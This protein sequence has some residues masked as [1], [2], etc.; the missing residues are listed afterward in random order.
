MIQLCSSCLGNG[1]N[2]LKIQ[3]FYFPSDVTLGQRI[4]T[5]CS[6]TWADKQEFLWYKQGKELQKDEKIDIRTFADIS[7]IIIDPVS[8]EHAGN[9]TC[10]VNAEGLTDSYTTTLNVLVPAIWNVVPKDQEVHIGETL[11]LMCA[12]SGKPT[13]IITWKKASVG[14]PD[15]FN[16]IS[17]KEGSIILSNGTMII[18]S[19]T[20]DDDGYYKC[21][22]TNNVGN[23]IEKNILIRVIVPA[24]FEEK[25][26]VQSV[27]RGDS[28]TLKCD[29]VGD[30]PMTIT[31][32]KDKKVID[33][34]KMTRVERFDR[35]QERG[36]NSELVIRTADRNDGALYTCVSKNEY[37]NDER[38]IKL[39]VVEVPAQPLDV[40]I[41]EVYSK[42]AT[43]K[44]SAPY[45]GNSPITKYI[46]QYWR[47]RGGAHRLLEETVPNSQTSI[48]LQ[49]LR[50]G[51]PYSVTVV[52]ENEIGQGEPSDIFRFITG[53]EEPS[54]PPTDVW[55][56]AKGSSMI[57]VSWK[58]PPRE[59][60]NG[61]LK[62]YFIG[63]KIEDPTLPFSFKTVYNV[64]N[65]THEYVLTNLMKSTKYTVVVKAYNSAGTGPPS[66]ELTAKTLDGDLPL[67]PSLALHS[68][69]DSAI[70]VKWGINPNKNIPVSGYTI[71]YK[72]TGGDWYHIPIIANS[73][74]HFTVT[75]L[76]RGTIYDVYITASNQYGNGEAGD[77]LKIKTSTLGFGG[78]VPFYLDLSIIIPVASSLLAFN[79]III[80]IAIYRRKSRARRNLEKALQGAAKPSTYTG[81]SQ[82]YI[83]I[84]KTRPANHPDMGTGA[85]S[86]ASYATI[87]SSQGQDTTQEIKTFYP[88]NMKDRP[89]PYP[90]P[91]CLPKKGNSRF[92]D[93][94]E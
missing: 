51:T 90:K 89:L 49:N 47:D 36:L 31:W 42:R 85:P 64:T 27:R 65:D 10:T 60:W 75:G 63:Y 30:K 88:P 45:S 81:S 80:V 26:A 1:I 32:S 19:V 16:T 17:M 72:K 33:F 38:N 74:N 56:K 44:W 23:P 84:N 73:Q 76:D 70:S 71:H 48:E 83:D 35:D 18:K 58:S 41:Q 24:R 62:G 92:Y 69:S 3:P 87:P 20:K 9:Y 43:I 5:I 22:A 25:F 68:A 55:I 4:T 13:P 2:K 66:Q 37:G 57:I 34:T 61:E 39:Q 86:V 79:V 82:R 28:A 29:A 91:V 7:T 14:T 11:S 50:P 52:A 40:K 21:Q 77:M 6:T 54:G 93:T 12:A 67:P 15:I 8:E 46:V 78:G 59:Y 94:A 53:E